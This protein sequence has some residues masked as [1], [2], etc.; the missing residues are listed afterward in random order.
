MNAFF[1][2]DT[3]SAPGQ[4]TIPPQRVS[5]HFTSTPPEAIYSFFSDHINDV[6]TV[7]LPI[8]AAYQELFFELV[9][10]K[11]KLASE[12]TWLTLDLEDA[13]N[14]LVGL[15]E[16]HIRE[17]HAHLSILFGTDILEQDHSKQQLTLSRLCE[18]SSRLIE[19]GA[20]YHAYR[21][22]RQLRDK[23][24]IDLL[25]DE[26]DKHLLQECLKKYGAARNQSAKALGFT[27]SF[28]RGTFE[29]KV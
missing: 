16:Q 7:A 21:W 4:D 10:G 13:R 8:P 15:E 28:P 3:V 19:R 5:V 11:A 23:R 22:M 2:N 1:K 12:Q 24:G 9:Q 25:T 29:E 6:D 17:N 20:T 18:Q 26:E 27:P 14:R